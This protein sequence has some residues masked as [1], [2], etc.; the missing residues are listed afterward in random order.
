[1]LRKQIKDAC[2]ISKCK[3]KLRKTDYEVLSKLIFELNIIIAKYYFGFLKMGVKKSQRIDQKVTKGFIGYMFMAK[4][5]PNMEKLLV[6][7]KPRRKK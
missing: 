1:M 2:V 4:F 7:P 3:Q 5:I 6:L